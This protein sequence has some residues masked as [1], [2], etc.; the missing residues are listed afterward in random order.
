MLLSL[1]REL[2]AAIEADPDGDAPRRA[3]AEHLRRA[4][5]FARS[6]FIRVQCDLAADPP[7]TEEER[8][9][10]LADEAHLWHL[11]HGHWAGSLE[12]RLEYRRGFG[13]ALA[14]DSDYDRDTLPINPETR[15]VRELYLGLSADDKFDPDAVSGLPMLRLIR[16]TPGPLTP[17]ARAGLGR[18]YPGVPVECGPRPVPRAIPVPGRPDPDTPTA[19]AGREL[20]YAGADPLC[21]LN[22]VRLRFR[23]PADAAA[24]VEMRERF[25]HVEVLSLTHADLPPDGLRRLLRAM[26]RLRMLELDGLRLDAQH[27]AALPRLPRLR[28]LRLSGHALPA[29]VPPLDAPRQL[30][31]EVDP[32]IRG[33]VFAGVRWTRRELAL[34]LSIELP[35]IFAQ[36]RHLE[37]RREDWHAGGSWCEDDSQGVICPD[38]GPMWLRWG[39][40]DDHDVTLGEWLGRHSTYHWSSLCDEDDFAPV[41]RR[42][43]RDCARRAKRSTRRT[44][45]EAAFPVADGRVLHLELEWYGDRL[46]PFERWFDEALDTLEEE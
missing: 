27:W 7:P 37:S 42:A 44:S 19:P 31:A 40:Y 39:V 2:W 14:F 28:E 17:K 43:G 23:A 18:V 29:E 35:D 45:L 38:T 1:P 33:L 24:L 10:L 11:Y 21:R 32:P 25:R 22:E 30:A 4:G 16:A 5:D 15:T 8:R 9:W 41:E 6:L 36:D 26:P 13:Y 3:A 12:G 46:L 20:A 34:G